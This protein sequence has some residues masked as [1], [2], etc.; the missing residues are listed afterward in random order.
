M[1]DP[2]FISFS[3]WK[4]IISS[5]NPIHKSSSNISFALHGHPLLLP[6]YRNCSST[7]GEYLALLVLM[8]SS[9]MVHESWSTITFHYLLFSI[10]FKT[11]CPE[12][13]NIIR[14]NKVYNVSIKNAAAI[15]NAVSTLFWCFRLF[16]SRLR[17]LYLGQN[18]GSLS[19]KRRRSDF[20]LDLLFNQTGFVQFFGLGKERIKLRESCF[21]TDYSHKEGFLQKRKTN[22]RDAHFHH[23]LLR[24]FFY[25]HQRPCQ[26]LLLAAYWIFSFHL[27]T[28]K[29]FLGRHMFHPTNR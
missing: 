8:F 7:L 15:H 17:T 29:T 3:A 28:L 11:L 20:A 13:T 14:S 19:I 6:A 10:F 9:C 26:L 25:R 22:W 18:L 5:F 24:I 27:L 2:N 12:K 4:T 16:A 21:I 1:R 23:K